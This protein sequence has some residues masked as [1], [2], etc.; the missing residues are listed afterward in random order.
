[1]KRKITTSIQKDLSRKIVLLTGP[2]QCGKTWLSKNLGLDHDY[3]SYDEGEHREIIGE[4]SWDR[5]KPLIILDELHKMPDWKRFLKGLYDVEGV[6][7]GLLITGSARLDINRKMGDSLA[8]RFFQHRLHPFD[9]RELADQMEP[10]TV[11]ERILQV[12]GFPEPFLLNDPDEA[13]RWRKTHLD[14][15]LRQDLLDLITVSDIHICRKMPRPSSAGFRFLRTSMWS[16]LCA[17]TIGILPGP[18]SKSQSTT[19]TMWVSSP[20]TPPCVWKMPWRH[21]S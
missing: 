2:R 5:K 8:G 4:K 21:H 11:L 13:R 3:L 6:P 1:M 19:S 14:V 15:I 9:V 20:R 17:P 16:F 18:F 7:P 12:G 10:Q